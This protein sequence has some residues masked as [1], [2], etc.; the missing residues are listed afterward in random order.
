MSPSSWKW[1]AARELTNQILPIV[2]AAVSL[3]TPLWLLMHLQQTPNGATGG[4]DDYQLAAD[5]TRW[6][7]PKYVSTALVGFKFDHPVTVVTWTQK[8]WVPSYEQPNP[9]KVS[10]DTWVTVVPFLKAFCQAYVRTQK[11]SD[12]QVALR[13]RQHLGLPPDAGYDTFVELTVDPKDNTANPGIFRPCGDSS[14]ETT[15]CKTP[16]IPAASEVWTS[17]ASSSQFKDQAQEWLLRNYDSNYAEERPY[18]WTELGYTFDW[19]RKENTDDFVRY[20][21][22]EF[23]IPKG[24]VVHFVSQASTAEYCAAQ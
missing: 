2:I 18:P 10:R 3:L 21:E 14:L 24:T 6:P 23:V 22:S 12:E 16:T 4:Q 20:G 5:Q 1:I 19:A 15:T 11:A 7:N 9:T 8:R 13:L 17:A